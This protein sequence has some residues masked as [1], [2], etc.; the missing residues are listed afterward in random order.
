MSDNLW[1]FDLENTIFSYVKTKIMSQL[2]SKYPDIFVTN[3]DWTT[4]KAVFPT[5][6]IHELSGIEQGMDING[7]S[8]NAVLTSFQIEVVTNTNQRDAKNI[9]A[10][11]ADIFKELRF[12]ITAMPEF[13]NPE[14]GTYRSIM[15]LRRVIGANDSLI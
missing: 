13:S 6:Y 9:I 3:A 12:T 4:F 11:V 15:R 14:Q 5:V 1:V 7:Q 2:K 10:I 8:I